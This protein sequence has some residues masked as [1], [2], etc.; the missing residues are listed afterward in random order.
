M[1]SQQASRSHAPTLLDEV[2]PEY[3]FAGRISVPVTA[4]AAELFHSLRDV[5][6]ADM[7]MARALGALRYL[8]GRLLG[9]GAPPPA[10][11]SAFLDQ[12]LSSGNMVLAEEANRELVLGAIGKFHQILNQQLWPL[13]EAEQF[14]AFHDPQYQKLAMSFRVEAGERGPRLTLEHRTHA[15]GSGSRRAFALY[16]VVIK[17]AGHFVSWLLLR[18]VR[19]RAE[20]RDMMSVPTVDSRAGGTFGT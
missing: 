10:E 14:H 20:H 4:S 18:A 11:Q 5:T 12:L 7:P 16:W 19:R 6:L 2:L 1:E 3:E 17:P 13:Q 15:L 9:K 8:P